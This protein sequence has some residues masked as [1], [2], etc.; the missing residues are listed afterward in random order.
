MTTIDLVCWDFGDTLIDER[1]MWTAPDG[2]PQWPVV[3]T[4]MFDENAEWI[5]R[6]MVGDAVMNE[7]VPWLATETGMSRAAVSRHLRWT[8]TQGQWFESSRH[9]VDRL[10]GRT[11]Q[12]VVTVN[13]YEFSG[14][15]ATIG[16]DALVD[17]IITSADVGREEKSALA[18]EA[19]RLLGLDVGLGTSLLIDN[20]QH[21]VD[22]F[23]AAGGHAIFFDTTEP[24]ALHAEMN[25][26][27]S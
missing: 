6:W 25:R 19:R 12:A 22:E 24:D 7:M 2:F 17:I 27:V 9:W 15:A 13:P 4:R 14:V 11:L 26:Y 18:Q 10:N 20:K 16:I 23:R 8:W 3:Y 21:N 5:D 1:M